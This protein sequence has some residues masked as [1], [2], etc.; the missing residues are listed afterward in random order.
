MY[1]IFGQGKDSK[2]ES[3]DPVFSL[4]THRILL[5][6]WSGSTGDALTMW[7]A[8]AIDTEC[9]VSKLNTNLQ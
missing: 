6:Y 4:N 7:S 1:V 5:L 9:L 2:D 3:T 8:S